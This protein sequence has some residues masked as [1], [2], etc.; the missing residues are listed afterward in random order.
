VLSF[1]V[2]SE[3]SR[4]ALAGIHLTFHSMNT[5]VLSPWEK[6]QGR[7]FDHSTKSGVEI[8]VLNTKRRLLYLKIQ[9]VPRCKHFSSRL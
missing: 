8:N 4:T 1:F 2:F 9:F 7:E 5:E 3:K 6:R